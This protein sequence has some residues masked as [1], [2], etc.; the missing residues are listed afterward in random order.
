MMKNKNVGKY[1]TTAKAALG[2]DGR[3]GA[4]MRRR[5]EA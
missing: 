2:E 1:R 4:G 3:A 5:V